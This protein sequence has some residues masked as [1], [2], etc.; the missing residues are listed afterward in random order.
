MLL[1]I[2]LGEFKTM[3]ENEQYFEAKD[4]DIS[5]EHV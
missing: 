1:A 2:V 3:T 5:F 4:L